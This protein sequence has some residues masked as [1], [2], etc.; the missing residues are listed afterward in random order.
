M[1]FV[2]RPGEKMIRYFHPEAPGLDYLPFKYDGVSWQEFP[3]E[4]AAYQIKTKDGPK[5][6]KD[7]RSW[8][9]GKIEYRPLAPKLSDGLKHGGEWSTVFRMPCP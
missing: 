7:A 3:Q 1:S 2:L 9:T 6:Q 8:G 4:I 5:S